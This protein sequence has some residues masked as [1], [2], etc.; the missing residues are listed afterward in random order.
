M[1]NIIGKR[2]NFFIFSSLL[3]L[4][5]WLALA[6]WGLKPSIDF[7][8]GSLLEFTFTQ[9]R[10]AGPEIES[11]V[12]S[13]GLG[14][15]IVQPTGDRGAILKL[16]FISEDEHQKILGIVRETYEKDNNKVLEERLETIGPAV[17]S[18]IRERAW[19]AGLTVVVAIV[20]YIAYAFRKV[21]R[22]IASWKYGVAAIVA[23]VHDV[24]I[25]M[26]VFAVLGRYFNVHVDIP[27]VVALLTILG[28]SV[29]DT[30]VVFDR[31]RENLI[32]RSANNFAE[33]AN[34][35]VNETIWRSVNTSVTVL[36]VLS[37]L[38]FFGGETIHFFT[39]ALIIGIF[40]GT[41]SSIFIASP[42]LVVWE[43]RQRR[44]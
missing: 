21:S 26:G 30:I 12:E 37:A 9:T 6:V 41:Y 35:A 23:L 36:L 3:V 22:P 32:R 2:N 20:A 15:V 8:G 44:G 18:V 33:V 40:F 28:Y 7:T 39:L 34:V 25:A 13:L 19:L 11:R 31:I 14:D 16:R 5:S 27:F 24:S 17:S 38:F 42:L 10:P 29:N 4:A 43:G 1:H